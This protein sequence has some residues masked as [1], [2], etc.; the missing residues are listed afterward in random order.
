L[1][2][3][4]IKI[5]RKNGARVQVKGFGTQHTSVWTDDVIW[6]A[7]ETNGLEH[8]HTTGNSHT[9]IALWQRVE[10][11]VGKY[12]QFA[13]LSVI[14]TLIFVLFEQKYPLTAAIDR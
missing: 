4:E 6:C 13:F 14:Y 11:Q 5:W 9:S 7:N 8:E 3:A 12:F 10:L 1:N 2:T